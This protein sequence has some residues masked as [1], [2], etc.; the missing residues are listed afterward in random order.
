MSMIAC[1]VKGCPVQDIRKN[2]DELIRV[3][4]KGGP[5]IGMC[6]HHYQE[7]IESVERASMGD[8]TK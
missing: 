8:T 2:P 5:F 1:A 4:P 7:W 6:R 3:S